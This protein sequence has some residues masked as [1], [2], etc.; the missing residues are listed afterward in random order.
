MREGVTVLIYS[1]KKEKEKG[2]MELDPQIP[3][4]ALV[5]VLEDWAAGQERQAAKHS[6]QMELLR[7]QAGLQTQALLQLAGGGGPGSSNIKKPNIHL[8]KMTADDDGQAFLEVFEVAAEACRWPQEEWMVRLLP[9]LSGEVQQAARSLPPSARANYS[10]VR[11]AVL[12]RTGYS[13][14]E[15]RW[16][17]RELVLA[18]GDRP[19]AYAQRLTDMARRWLQP[20]IRLVAGVVEEVETGRRVPALVKAKFNTLWTC[21]QN[22]TR[23]G[24]CHR[25]IC[26][27]LKNVNSVCTIEGRN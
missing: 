21:E 18:T 9:L 6:E 20:E 2:D 13:L 27:R 26:S 24:N 4:A 15:Q 1:K 19:F 22:S 25:R 16:R 8:P 3:V 10:N 17:F 23:W 5:K 14:E 7:V 11:K 12:D